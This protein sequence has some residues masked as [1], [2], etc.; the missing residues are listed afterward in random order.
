MGDFNREAA[1]ELILGGMAPEVAVLVAQRSEGP[2]IA[3]IVEPTRGLGN[4]P[5]PACVARELGGIKDP[6]RQDVERALDICSR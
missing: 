1:V 5:D 3:W 6:T 4:T 2:R